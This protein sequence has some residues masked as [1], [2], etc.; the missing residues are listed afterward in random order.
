MFFPFGDRETIMMGSQAALK[1]R[2]P[3][4]DQM[5]R[6]DRRADPTFH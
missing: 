2:I 3:V 5:M 6:G 1:H 4:N